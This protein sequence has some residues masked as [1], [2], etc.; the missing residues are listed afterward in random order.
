MKPGSRGSRAWRWTPP[1]VIAVLAVLA[2]RAV[3]WAEVAAR[4]G[5]ASPP[6]LALAT[7]AT[8]MAVAARVVAWWSLLQGIGVSSFAIA[9]RAAIVGMA[10][11]CVLIANAGE[12]HRVGI[13]VREAKVGTSAVIA[14]V[15]IERLIVS[16]PF[17]LFL[18]AAGLMLPLP[19]EL[20]RWRLIVLGAIAAMIIGLV[21]LARPI[22]HA[23]ADRPMAAGCRLRA[24]N[25]LR[26]FRES[27][28]VLLSAG[29]TSLVLGLAVVHWAFQIVAL[30]LLEVALQLPMP[31]VG[32]LLALLGMSASGS[33]RLAPGNLGLNQLVYA[34]TAATFGLEPESALGVA[35]VL[36]V[37]QTVPLLLL[38]LA[39][40]ALAG[41]SGRT[42]QPS[43]HTAPSYFA[44][45]NSS[46]TRP[47]QGTRSECVTSPAP[48][49]PPRVWLPSFNRSRPL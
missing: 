10:I 40:S 32:T 22:G 15:V 34:G 33:V 38:A 49:R 20:A 36:Q 6:M 7:A 25:A 16:V 43:S 8:Y 4:I 26:P 28:R 13:V 45:R 18:A 42:G 23:N 37:I 41:I 27:L 19:P 5:D 29:R 46:T 14:T 30:V 21:L 24:A 48:T 31:L 39:M 12:I 2:G 35:M 17:A 44:L 11:N 47:A 9:S 3:P 1:A